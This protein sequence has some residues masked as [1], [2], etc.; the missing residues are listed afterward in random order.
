MRRNIE[1]IGRGSRVPQ[2]TAESF[3]L[4][5]IKMGKVIINGKVFNYTGRLT[6]VNNK[7]FVDSKEITDWESLEKDQKHIDIKIEGDVERLLVETCDNL[8]IEGNCNRVKTVSG[9][10]EIGGDVDGDVESVSGDISVSGSVSGDVKTV[11]GNIR[12]R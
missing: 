10:V 11:S 5:L 7:F 1:D 4:T 2:C 9:D 8:Y 12:R 3:A 6:V